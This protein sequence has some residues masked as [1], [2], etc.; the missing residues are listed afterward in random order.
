MRMQTRRR[1]PFSSSPLSTAKRGLLVLSLTLA[2]MAGAHGRSPR[3]S[4]AFA[5]STRS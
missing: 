5:R 4:S 2:G 1:S 3:S